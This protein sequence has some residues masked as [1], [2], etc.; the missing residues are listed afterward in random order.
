MSYN[1]SGPIGTILPNNETT[2]SNLTSGTGSAG[3]NNPVSFTNTSITLLNSTSNAYMGPVGINVIPYNVSGTGGSSILSNRINC[4]FDP[5]SLSKIYQMVTGST[6]SIRYFS[7]ANA[8][9]MAIASYNSTT[10]AATAGGLVNN[11]STN[12]LYNGGT[13]I[14]TAV[15]DNSL[16]ILNGP[17]QCSKDAML[18]NGIYGIGYY[19]YSSSYY[20]PN[21]VNNI[22]TNYIPATGGTRYVTFGW[23][24]S[25]ALLPFQNI[26]FTING[27]TNV[28]YYGV[29]PSGI[30]YYGLSGTTTPLIFFYRLEDSTNN[31]NAVNW[32]T[33]GQVSTPWIN[34]NLIPT[35]VQ[36]LPT[37]VN[38]SNIYFTPAG[39]T[40]ST[41][42]S[43][44]ATLICVLGNKISS[45]N[46]TSKMTLYCRIGLQNG[47][48]FTGITYSL[49]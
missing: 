10:T 1:Q 18:Y 21:Q 45:S 43:N 25:N 38:F 5:V 48:T 46:K 34:G 35:G 6:G 22:N 23:D 14:S 20:G 44:T 36:S 2:L 41:Y 47:T 33:G 39:L 29:S 19:D 8:A 4:I 49:S 15:Y 9:N 26:T 11:T 30:L 27:L 12:I 17:S 16:T 28:N 7:T 31:A 42:T 37:S 40:S 32:P 24:V 13:Y 3:F